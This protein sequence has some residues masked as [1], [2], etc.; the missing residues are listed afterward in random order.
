M[1]LLKNNIELNVKTKCIEEKATQAKIA[2]QIGTSEAYISRIIN[3]RE[4]IINK[5]FFAMMEALGYDVQ[6]AYV[7]REKSES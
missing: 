6:L 4:Q 3:G 1:R 5:T 7:K 2:D